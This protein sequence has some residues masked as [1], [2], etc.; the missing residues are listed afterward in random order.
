MKEKLTV[1][2]LLF[3]ENKGGD[4][5][6][7]LFIVLTNR[8]KCDTIQIEKTYKENSTNEERKEAF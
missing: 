5:K 3:I 2:F 8:K 1:Y 6:Q 4:K 7:I